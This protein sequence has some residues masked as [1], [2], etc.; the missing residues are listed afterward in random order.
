MCINNIR[1]SLRSFTSE[2]LGGMHLL[3]IVVVTFVY[4]KQE[5]QG[6][7]MQ[8]VAG[9]WPETVRRVVAISYLK[10]I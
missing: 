3:D 4:I 7:G 9:N 8:V 1:S 2:A 10:I 6:K 5:G